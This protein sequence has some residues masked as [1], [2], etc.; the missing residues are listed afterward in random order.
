MPTTKTK[1]ENTLENFAGFNNESEI[2]FFETGPAEDTPI[3]KV[4]EEEEE[5]ILK[6]G[7]TKPVVKEIE[8]KK[9]KED[10]SENIDFF[11][12]EPTITVEDDDPDV[13]TIE[14]TVITPNMSTLSHLKEKGYIDYE[15]EDGQELTEELAEQIVED[16][17]DERVEGR[18]EELFA[19]VPDSVKSIVKYA[20]GGG[21]VNTLLSSMAKQNASPVKEDMDMED[22]SNQILVVKADRIAQGEDSETAEAYTDF[23]KESGKLK[24]VAEKV[25]VSVIAKQKQALKQQ[26]EAAGEKKKQDKINQRAFKSE[27]TDTVNKAETLNGLAI[28]KIDKRELPTYMADRTVKLEDGRQVTAMQRDLFKAMQ[29]KDKSVILAKLLKNDFNFN[30][31]I[32]GAKTKYT[33]EIKRDITRSSAIS[34]QAD[35]T[36][37]GKKDLASYF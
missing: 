26:F 16:N 9:E 23:L 25:H 30:G 18:V 31:I 1:T 29:D 22:E 27:L 35:K 7:E 20:I 8:I 28:T 14:D 37:S 34:R 12:E 11:E 33:K 13:T 24:T 17:F 15:L 5:V 36:K 6:E 3:E 4:I 10:D 21:N 2:D 19:E 32:K